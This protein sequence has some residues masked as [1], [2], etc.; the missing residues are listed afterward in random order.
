MAEVNLPSW[1]EI[2]QA[3][4]S[5]QLTSTAATW[6]NILARL[7]RIE[8]RLLEHERRVAATLPPLQPEPDPPDRTRR[9]TSAQPPYPPYQPPYQPDPSSH[10]YTPQR[11]EQPGYQHYFHNQPTPS[12]DHYQ[13][14]QQSYRQPPFVTA[15]LP[16]QNYPQLPPLKP[17]QPQPLTSPA[18]ATSPLHQN[19][20]S[21]PPY[22]HQPPSPYQ[23]QLLSQPPQQ[24]P[25]KAFNA[26]DQFVNMPYR[27]ATTWD[28]PGTHIVLEPQ[29]IEQTTCWVHKALRSHQGYHSYEQ[30]TVVQQPLPQRLPYCW[31]PLSHHCSPTAELPAVVAAPPLADDSRQPLCLHVTS[32]MRTIM[33]DEEQLG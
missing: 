1:S 25:R 29:A 14:L 21:Q 20:P 17:Y 28:L 12:N 8:S 32:A 23:Q 9:Y 18:A 22:A 24:S 15:A 31:N 7:A 11:R 3:S 13:S 4:E 16:H 33:V 5:L 19:H 30:P 26:E 27:M 6:E 10:R 2:S